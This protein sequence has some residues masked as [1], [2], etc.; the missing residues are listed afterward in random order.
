MSTSSVL[1]DAWCAVEEAGL[2]EKIHEVAFREAVRLIV[3]PS[4]VA[5]TQAGR[6]A[7]LSS[8]SGGAGS[9]GSDSSSGQVAGDSITLSEDELL[10]KV[11]AGTGAE[12]DVLTNLVHLEDG[13]LRISIPGIK[14]GKNNADKTRM[15]ARI[16]TIVR[17]F[18]LNEDD[19]LVEMVRD[20]AQRL[21]CYDSA[22]FSSQ[23]KVLQGQGYV[24]KGAGGNRRIQAKGTGISEFPGLVSKLLGDS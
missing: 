16:F 12:L 24:I 22:N 20:E 1:K 4:S 10:Q 7:K 11:A 8:S 14:M 5:P 19:T 9:K 17:A 3:P 6:A 21:K 13:G 18:G 2:P 23:L 15:I